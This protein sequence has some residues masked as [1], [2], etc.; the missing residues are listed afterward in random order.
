M[1]GP[2]QPS[3]GLCPAASRG[4][5]GLG[6]RTEGEERRG[7]MARGEREEGGGEGEEGGGGG[8]GRRRRGE[9]SEREKGERGEERGR[10]EVRAFESRCGPIHCYDQESPT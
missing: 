2:C 1:Q 5:A 3:P 8:G 7:D 9:Q 10:R 6:K 4:R